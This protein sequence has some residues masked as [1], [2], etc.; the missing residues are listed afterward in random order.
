MATLY[1]MGL[2]IVEQWRYGGM[3]LDIK[4]LNHTN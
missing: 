2:L 3:K 4:K 1:G